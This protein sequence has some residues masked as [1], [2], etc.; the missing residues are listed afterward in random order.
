M[1][2]WQEGIRATAQALLSAVADEGGREIARK[3]KARLSKA[4][5]T[6]DGEGKTNTMTTTLEDL[7]RRAAAL[8]QRVRF[9][10]KRGHIDFSQFD[11]ASED[12]PVMARVKI[13]DDSGSGKSGFGKDS[14]AA[15]RDL[16]ANLKDVLRDRIKADQKALA[17]AGG[18]D[19]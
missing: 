2:W 13:V 6:P 1:K 15:V 4:K 8:E 3:I 17:D 18:A 19:A 7:M 5:P 10:D 11:S 9:S 16:C 12:P 14:I